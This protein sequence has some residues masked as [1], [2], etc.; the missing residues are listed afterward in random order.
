MESELETE[1]INAIRSSN[2]SH[3][4]ELSGLLREVNPLSLNGHLDGALALRK[5]GEMAQS[6]S[7]IFEA[8]DKL[9]IQ[10]QFLVVLADNAMD[11]KEWG[12]AAKRW[13]SL[14]D[15]YPEDKRGWIGGIKSL[16]QLDH[17][18]EIREILNKCLDIPISEIIISESEIH[19]NNRINI[20][21]KDALAA[22]NEKHWKDAHDLY[23]LLH[24]YG[25]ED[26]NCY[27]NTCIACRMLGYWDD[28]DNIIVKAISK[29]GNQKNLLITF[30]DTAMDSKNWQDALDRWTKVKELFPDEIYAYRRAVIAAKKTG[31]PLEIAKASSSYINT[32]GIEEPNPISWF[33]LRETSSKI[34]KLRRICFIQGIGFSGHSKYLYLYLNRNKHYLDIEVFWVTSHLKEYELLLSNNLPVLFWDMSPINSDFLLRTDIAIYQTHEPYNANIGLIQACL[35]AAIKVQLWHGIPAKSVGY[36]DFLNWDDLNDDFIRYTYDSCMYDY[37]II[38]SKDLS[39]TYSNVFPSAELTPL[40]GCRTDALLE[41][42]LFCDEDLWLGSKAPSQT[43]ANKKLILYAPTYREKSQDITSFIS[44][45]KEF[46]NYFSNNKDYVLAIKP[47]PAFIEETDLNFN[48][49]FSESDNIILIKGHEDIYPWCARAD[50]LITDYSSIYYDYLITK[51]PIIF[52]QPDRDLYEKTRYRMI[53]PFET[54]FAPGPIIYTAIDLDKALIESET[55][56]WQLNRLL[57]AEKFHTSPHDGM[58]TKRVSDFIVSLL[59]T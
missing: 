38:E 3:A 48:D 59:R 25:V 23:N 31:I 43:I 15:T 5:I 13:A 26:Q 37:V 6:D 9:G 2:W 1:L 42:P 21:L 27:L 55:E 40:G 45:V 28:A 34:K 35:H 14:R 16:L 11:F 10:L 36:T 29:F 19:I 52:F 7:L 24:K 46:I 50:F 53:Y 20:L 30:A 44:A 33:L 47:H 12:E 49:L 32:F 8:I 51:K 54:E 18:D 58:T 39:T 17:I 57:L 22:F 4:I 56:T 41:S